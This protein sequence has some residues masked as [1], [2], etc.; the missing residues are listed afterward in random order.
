MYV[1]KLDATASTNQYLKQRALDNQLNDYTVVVTE[2]QTRGRGQMGAEW[3]SEPGKN[4]TFSILKRFNDFKAINQVYFNCAVALALYDT[5]QDLSVPDVKVKWPNDIMSGNQ[6]IC[7]ILIE[8]ILRGNQISQSV[9]GIGLN[10]NQRDFGVL[11]KVSSLLLLLGRTIDIDKLMNK[12]VAKLKIRI[13]DL[14]STNMESIKHTY[15][16]VLFRKDEPS[17]FKAKDGTNFMGIIKGLSIEG[18][19]IVLPEQGTLK[20]FGVKEIQLLY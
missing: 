4:L 6:K 10:V 3:I 18:K 13:N 15:E 16:S 8:N 12:V 7:G 19:L 11:K 9:I 2:K 5:L 14:D 1:I 17:A 20:E